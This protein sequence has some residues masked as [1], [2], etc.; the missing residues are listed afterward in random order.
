[1]DE[2]RWRFYGAKTRVQCSHS[3]HTELK[4]HRSKSLSL[5]FFTFHHYILWICVFLFINKDSLHSSC[6]VKICSKHIK[7]VHSRVEFKLLKNGSVML[8]CMFLQTHRSFLWR[9]VSEVFL[10][11][12]F[13]SFSTFWRS[14]SWRCV[15]VL[16][17]S[18]ASSNISRLSWGQYLSWHLLSQICWVLRDSAQQSVFLQSLLR[19]LLTIYTFY[20]YLG[21]FFFF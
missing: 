12:C 4:P 2:S 1:M 9:V 19:F 15:R 18:R 14:R 21:F 16:I 17:F 8:R 6:T 3:I 20:S 10:T 7:G 11:V 13:Y 5:S